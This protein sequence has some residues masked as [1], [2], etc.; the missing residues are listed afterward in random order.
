MQDSASCHKAKN[1]KKFFKEHQIDLLE[2]PVNSPDWNSI[3]NYWRKM[4]KVMVEK[5]TPNLDTLKSK[6][7]TYLMS[8]EDVRNLCDSMPKHLQMIFKNKSN[9]TKY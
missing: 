8:V 7:K 9:M 4:T 6:L 1:V 3:E 2:W 5:K